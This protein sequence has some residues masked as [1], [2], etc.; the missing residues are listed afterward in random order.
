ME[1]VRLVNEDIDVHG[2]LISDIK[3][4]LHKEWEV[5]RI[6]HSFREG[7]NYADHVVKLGAQRE[8]LMVVCESPPARISIL[9]LVDAIGVVYLRS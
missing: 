5:I 6:S 4:L 7:S 1:A 9:L 3:A 2:A 8:E